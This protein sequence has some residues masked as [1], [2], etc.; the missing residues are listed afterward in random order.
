[1]LPTS[2]TDLAVGIVSAAPRFPVTC[3]LYSSLS[4]RLGN[5]LLMIRTIALS[6]KIR[7]CL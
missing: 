1:M 2:A 4:D 5:R 6:D 7:E 3:S